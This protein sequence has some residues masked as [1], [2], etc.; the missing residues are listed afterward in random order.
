MLSSLSDASTFLKTTKTQLHLQGHPDT[1]QTCG[2]NVCVFAYVLYFDEPWR[3]HP[4]LRVAAF[5]CGADRERGVI[6]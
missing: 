3:C 4:L 1:L 2:V 6:G 5:L